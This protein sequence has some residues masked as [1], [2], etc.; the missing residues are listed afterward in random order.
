MSHYLIEPSKAEMKMLCLIARCGGSMGH[1]EPALN[2][3]CNDSVPVD[4]FNACSGH[5]WTRNTH[6]YLTDA[7]RVHLT[8]A[9]KARVWDWENSEPRSREEW[10]SVM[11]GAATPFADNH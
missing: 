1:D 6:D 11:D 4:V 5:G 8:D 7:S 10:P 3:F 2:E 9:G